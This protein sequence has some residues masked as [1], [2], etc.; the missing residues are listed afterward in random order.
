MM[1]PSIALA[2]TIAIANDIKLIVQIT[3]DGFRG[4]LLSRYEP[5]FGEGGFRRL[6]EGGVWY[7]N[8]HHLHAKTE[9]IVGHTTLST[10]ANPSEHGMI[11]NAWLDRAT[12]RLGYNIEDISSP[13]L[14]VPGFA[15]EG[16]QLDPAQA[17]AQASGRSPKNILASTFADE[18][19][20]ANNGGSRIVAISGK[21]RSAVAMAGHV[22]KAFWMSTSTGAY[23]TSTYYYDAYPDWVL[24]W[25]AARPADA[26]IGTSWELSDPIETYLLAENDDRPYEVDLK[27]FGRTFPHAYGDPT[28]GLYYTQ[29][30][31]SA[32]GDWLTADF[33]KA[34]VIGE[35]LGGGDYPDLLSVSFSGVDAVNHFFDPSSLENEETVRALD[36]TL[37]DFFAFLDERVGPE[38]LL[39]VLSGDHGMPEMPEFMAEKGFNVERNFNQELMNKVNAEV[40]EAVGVEGA[41]GQ[42]FRPYI[43]LNDEAIA[44]AG[45]ERQIVERAIVDSLMNQ[46]GIA[47]AMPR[48]PLPE[49]RGD[50]LE[51][52]IQRNFHP[53]RSG[54]IYVAQAPYS[55]LFEEGTVAVMHGSPWNYDTHVPIIFAGSGID[56]AIVS[57]KVGT[58]DVAVTLSSLFGTTQPS[59]ASGSVLDEVVH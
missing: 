14:P 39:F 35:N 43:Y 20:K 16:D 6:T 49:H 37:A 53:L 23:E 13:L 7:T 32:F 47:K 8:A 27:G 24:E 33:A 56:P 11:G 29:V 44:D 17:I 51:A 25:N 26:A 30:L 50:Y 52:P 2:P 4:D 22:G 41:I 34:A 42:F 31:V 58:V 55:F 9:T 28:D 36:R 3:V 15:G 40:A 38:H 1:L 54:D 45:V 18:L 19:S 57:R 59:G 5:S 21:D 10:G 12:G 46:P 48:Q